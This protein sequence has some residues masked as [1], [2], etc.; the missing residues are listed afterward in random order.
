MI[1][2]REQV[3]GVLELKGGLSDRLGLHVGD[4]VIHSAF[5]RSDDHENP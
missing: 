2:S 1:V 3:K 5:V 4:R